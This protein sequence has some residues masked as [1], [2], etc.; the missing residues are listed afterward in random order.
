MNFADRGTRELY[1][2]IASKAAR[3][4]VP[5]ALRQR[6]IDKLTLLEAAVSLS[7]LQIPPGNRLEALHGDRAGQHSIRINDQYRICFRWTEAGAIDVEIVDYH[8][9]R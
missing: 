8:S 7:Q 5:A 4:V 6:A 2:G 3:R 1:N 9:R